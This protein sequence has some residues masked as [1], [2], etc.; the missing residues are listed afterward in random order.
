M[1]VND[2]G[3]GEK[4]GALL[5]GL[6]GLAFALQ[7]ALTRWRHG[8]AAGER[9]SM[10]MTLTTKMHEEFNRINAELTEAREQRAETHALIH[11]QAKKLARMEL[12]L[13]RM[14]GLL[15]HHNVAIPADVQSGMESILGELP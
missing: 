9:A 13:T 2:M 11:E 15:N 8:A 10:E 6:I 4:V 14:Y 12:M 1:N 7:S 3:F 5:A